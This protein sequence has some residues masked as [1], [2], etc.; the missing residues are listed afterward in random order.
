VALL[1]VAV[2]GMF[3]GAR[4][5]RLSHWEGIAL[6]AGM[7]SRGVVAI[8][9]ASVGL[10][11]GILSTAMYTIIVAIA[12]VTSLMSPA[13]LRPAARPVVAATPHADDR[14]LSRRG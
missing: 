3:I 9:V 13:I 10:Q 5:S 1:C 12:F 6:G 14:D 4:A 8:I 11:R 2:A 7:N